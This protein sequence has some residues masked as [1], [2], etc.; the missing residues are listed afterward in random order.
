M[1]HFEPDETWLVVVWFKVFKD[2]NQDVY[3]VFQKLNQIYCLKI[4][5]NNTMQVK[6]LKAS[7]QG[8]SCPPQGGTIS[9][10]LHL[11]HTSSPYEHPSVALNSMA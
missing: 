6:L 11:A 1:S 7:S 3:G 9:L 2:R 4:Q 10:V 5:G 8:T